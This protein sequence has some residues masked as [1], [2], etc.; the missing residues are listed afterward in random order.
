MA[1]ILIVGDASGPRH[2]ARPHR[3]A[4][5]PAVKET[6]RGRE[7]AAFR[8]GPVNLLD[9]AMAPGAHALLVKPFNARRADGTV[10]EPEAPLGHQAGSFCGGLR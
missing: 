5:G 10:R 2:A 3:A 6:A 1:G 8:P 7:A 9:T 4:L